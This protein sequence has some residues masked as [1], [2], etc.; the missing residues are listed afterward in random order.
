VNERTLS[1]DAPAVRLH[2]LERNPAGQPAVLLLHG[3]LDHGRGFD[4]LC[5]ALPASWR[6][7]ALDFRGHGQSGHVAG[8]LYHLPD[9]L[10]DVDFTLDALGVAAVH[11]VGH[12]LGGTVALVYAAARPERVRSVTSIESLGPWGG[13]PHVHVDRLRRFVRDL[14]K[15]PLKRRYPDVEAAAARLREGN[16][17]L[18]EAAA[19]HLVRHGTRAVQGGVEFTFDPAHRRAFGTSLTEE[20]TLAFFGAVACPVQLIL[21]TRGLPADAPQLAKR[22]EALRAPAPIRVPGGHHVHLEEPGEVA[23]HV[24]AFVARVG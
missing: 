19:L 16:P 8:G 21:G 13:G 2:A 10:A 1:I 14:H 22:L 4:P 7:V 23:R 5:A 24:A 6:T 12:S 3:Y 11:L 17:A 9:Y 18:P 20:Q 15:P